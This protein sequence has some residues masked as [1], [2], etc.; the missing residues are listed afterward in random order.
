MKN[1]VRIKE[2]IDNASS[3]PTECLEMILAIAKGMA[4]TKSCM[5]KKQ[6]NLNDTPNPKGGATRSLTNITLWRE[7]I[8]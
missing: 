4:F 7:T 3:L 1:E 8:A 2:I 5:E 6:D